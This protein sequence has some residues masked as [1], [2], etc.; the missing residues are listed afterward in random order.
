MLV[1][2]LLVPPSLSNKHSH[3]IILDGSEQDSLNVNGSPGVRKESIDIKVYQC[4]WN[5]GP[6]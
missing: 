4:V 6:R 2:S 3:V 5:H 1:S